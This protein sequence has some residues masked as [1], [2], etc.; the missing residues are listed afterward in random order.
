MVLDFSD[1]KREVRAVCAE[2]HERTLVPMRSDVVSVS[3]AV[4]E[5][6]GQEV[7]LL[8]DGGA[9]RYVL[10]KADCCCLPLVHT[11]AEELAAHILGRLL[12]ALRPALLQRGCR[13]I[14][15]AVSESP[16]QEAVCS[17]ALEP[18][19]LGSP[20][21]LSNENLRAQDLAVVDAVADAGAVAVALA[22]SLDH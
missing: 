18:P 7:T 8:C 15:V 4:A 14:E 22:T 13:E 9:A 1:I 3:E 20:S 12:G 2:M 11:T 17:L 6:F 21:R 5:R 10:P 16:G 19:D